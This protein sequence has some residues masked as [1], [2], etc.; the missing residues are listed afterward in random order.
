MSHSPEIIIFGHEKQTFA[1]YNGITLPL[2]S[3]P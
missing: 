1:G 3:D 2:H